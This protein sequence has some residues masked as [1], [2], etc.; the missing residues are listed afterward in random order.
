MSGIAK[1]GG[2]TLPGKMTITL[3]EK[4]C[5]GCHSC[6]LICS[7]HHAQVFSHDLSSINV[8]VINRTGE[9]RWSVDETSCDLCE[10]EKVPLCV[11]FCPLHCLRM[12]EVA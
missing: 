3:D 9:R 1:M 8:L 6:E 4:R 5:T 12:R 2:K 10:G 7:F 11:K